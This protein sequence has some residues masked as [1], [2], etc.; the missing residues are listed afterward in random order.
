[1]SPGASHAARDLN[2]KHIDHKS[3]LSQAIH[4]F[5]KFQINKDQLS[6]GQMSPRQ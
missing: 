4:G 3:H 5:K 6:V 1:M 2:F